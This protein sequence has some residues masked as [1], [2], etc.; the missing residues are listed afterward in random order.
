MRCHGHAL[1]TNGGGC[2]ACAR[3]TTVG[4]CACR[5]ANFAADQTPDDEQN[6][7]ETNDVDDAGNTVPLRPSALIPSELRR[8]LDSNATLVSC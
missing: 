3:A 2:C 8:H 5:C 1:T 7:D 4:L 6:G